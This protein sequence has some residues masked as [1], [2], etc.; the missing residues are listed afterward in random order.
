[1]PTTIN[2]QSI[3][4]IVKMLLVSDVMPELQEH[5]SNSENQRRFKEWQKRRQDLKENNHY[6]G[7]EEVK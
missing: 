1:M 5:F 7:K 2:Y 4:R 3:P 6:E